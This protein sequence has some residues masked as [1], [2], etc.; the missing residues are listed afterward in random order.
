MHYQVRHRKKNQ[1]NTEVSQVII[2]YFSNDRSR[3][4]KKNIQKHRSMCMCTDQYLPIKNLQRLFTCIFLMVYT[5]NF[6]LLSRAEPIWT[7]NGIKMYPPR[8]KLKRKKKLFKWA[9]HI[10]VWNWN[11]VYRNC[12]ENVP[13]RNKIEIKRNGNCMCDSRRCNS[14]EIIYSWESEQ[15]LNHTYESTMNMNIFVIFWPQI[16]VMLERNVHGNTQCEMYCDT[17]LSSTTTTTTTTAT[18]NHHIVVSFWPVVAEPVRR[19]L[20]S[21]A[22]AHTPSSHMTHKHTRISHTSTINDITL[23]RVTHIGDEFK[24]LSNIAKSAHTETLA[25]PCDEIIILE[26]N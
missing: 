16:N 15:R 22:C 7:I 20:S 6:Q 5:P 13:V 2:N 21:C 14:A 19:L 11:C 4:G 10:T 12:I 3:T 23:Q 8:A 9:W 25:Y 17:H 26:C 18:T 1:Y 24:Q